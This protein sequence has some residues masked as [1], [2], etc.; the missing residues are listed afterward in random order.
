MSDEVAPLVEAEPRSDAK[1]FVACDAEEE[2]AGA[3]L[4]DGCPNG[5]DDPEEGIAAGVEGAA[6]A[7]PKGF[8]AAVPKPEKPLNLGAGAGYDMSVK[9]VVPD[10]MA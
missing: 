1:F 8:V 3:S 2:T 5:K 6:G 10:E 9:E 7:L 4:E